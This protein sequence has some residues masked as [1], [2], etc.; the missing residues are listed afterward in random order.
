[1][2]NISLLDVAPGVSGDAGVFS[3]QGLK[4]F[5]SDICKNGKT[6]TIRS[7]AYQYISAATWGSKVRYHLE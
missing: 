6:K 4:A 5:S 3:G 1:M 7:T 2:L